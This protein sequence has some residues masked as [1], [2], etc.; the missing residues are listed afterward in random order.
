[1]REDLERDGLK[2]E[3]A[4]SGLGIFLGCHSSG[5][6]DGDAFW[7]LGE[8]GVTLGA[9]SPALTGSAPGEGLLRPVPLGRHLFGAEDVCYRTSRIPRQPPALVQT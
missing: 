5:P 6:T 1:M 8:M 4:R 2:A 3:G 9:V 7:E